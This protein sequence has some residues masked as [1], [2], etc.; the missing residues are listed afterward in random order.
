MKTADDIVKDKNSVII[1]I[2]HNQTVQQACEAMLNNKIGAIVIR[3][4]NEYVG[5]FSERDLLQ[6]ITMGGFNPQSA[7]VGDYMSSPIHTVSHD[8]PLHKLEE[9]F[10]GLFVRHLLVEKE[11]E[12]IGMISI[13]DVL[14]ANLL[15]KNQ[16]F[17]DL[18]SFVSWEYYENWGWDR[19][20]RK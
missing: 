13:G 7:R 18:E 4:D 3:K 9:T 17:N 1:S 6:N 2:P 10:L 8:T 5:I 16:K 19:K 20:K 11:G 12:H 15:E 14:R